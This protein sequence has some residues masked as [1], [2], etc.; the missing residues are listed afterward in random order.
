ML[1]EN[2]VEGNLH[3]CL[4]AAANHSAR[5]KMHLGFSANNHE[6]ST[7]NI[8]SGGLGLRNIGPSIES[9]ELEIDKT[10][11]NRKK[12]MKVLTN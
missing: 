7:F 10:G 1:S 9:I 2:F 5:T 4:G 12:I 11:M 8:S 3:D 6:V